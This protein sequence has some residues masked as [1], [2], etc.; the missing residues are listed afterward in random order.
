V[1]LQGFID[2][3]MN[4]YI[5]DPDALTDLFAPLELSSERLL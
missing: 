3:I 1:A 2:H 4:R 5:F